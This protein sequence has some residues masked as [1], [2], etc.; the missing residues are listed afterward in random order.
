WLRLEQL[1]RW[2][3]WLLLALVVVMG[4]MFVT[5]WY[6]RGTA[7]QH[8]AVRWA[9]WLLRVAALAA[10][11]LYFLQFDKLTEQRVVRDSR[12]AVLVDTS[13]SMSQ[14]GTPSSIGVSNSRSRTEEVAGLLAQTDFLTRLSEQHQLSVYRFDQ[15]PRPPLLA[16]FEKRNH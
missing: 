8:R 13:L 15:L 14:P 9:L 12:V 4:M 6:R 10:L 16:A 2:W 3:H 11:L 7:E 1:D 5:A